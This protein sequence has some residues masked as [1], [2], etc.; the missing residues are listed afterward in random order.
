LVVAVAALVVVT[1]VCVAS[2]G[3]AGAAKM[4]T[5]TWTGAAAKKAVSPNDEWSDGANWK[6]GKAPTA[7]AP[8]DL[9]F[10]SFL[11]PTKTPACSTGHNDIAGL[12]VQTLTITSK[13]GK[14]AT[15][16]PSLFLSG[17]ALTLMGGIDAT[18]KLPKKGNVYLPDLAV[19]LPIQLGV[20]QTWKL[21][22]AQVAFLAPVTGSFNL[23]FAFQDDGGVDFDVSGND[24]ASVTA[25]G[26][27]SLFVAP[28]F[29]LNADGNP[30]T[31]DGSLLYDV[32][33]IGP[34]VTSGADV[35]VGNLGSPYGTMQVEGGATFDGA[36]EIELYDLTAG[37][38]TPTPGTDYPQILTTGTTSLGSIGL[39]VF[40]DCDL[41]LGTT[42]T[43]LDASGGVSGTFTEGMAMPTPTAT[44]TDGMI[45]E[46]PVDLDGDASCLKSATPSYLHFAYT[47]DTV[48]ATVV[49]APPAPAIVA[50]GDTAAGPRGDTAA[51]PRGDT[52]ARIRWVVPVHD[53]TAGRSFPAVAPGRS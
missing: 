18:T 11:C 41:P 5:Y 38:G 44:I 45:L 14:S 21:S 2:G 31:V 16:D 8:V 25:S 53:V 51:G 6:G 52:A 22:G 1:G 43:L 23:T 27:G 29:S 7:S 3:A 33:T 47:A 37:S 9:A 12:T 50:H 35:A 32:G 19:D 13:A 4:K 30:V 48:T 46:A 10:A 34:L 28:G 26:L 42:Y 49:A 24:V 17:D 40:A 15:S 20:D 39:D 36:S